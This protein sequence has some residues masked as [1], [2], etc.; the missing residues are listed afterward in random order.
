MGVAGRNSGQSPVLVKNVI[1]FM[2]LVFMIELVLGFIVG[3]V[4][5][6]EGSSEE[7]A[8]GE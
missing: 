2:Q 4:A 3:G 5:A 6:S 1:Q 7:A 8:L